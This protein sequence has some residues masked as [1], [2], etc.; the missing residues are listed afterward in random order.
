M[1][2]EVL[3]SLVRLAVI[4]LPTILFTAPHNNSLNV[5]AEK[6]GFILDCW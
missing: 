1:R 5:V 4:F 3:V 6:C 2:G